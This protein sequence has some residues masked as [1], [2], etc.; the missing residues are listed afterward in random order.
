MGTYEVEFR[1]VLMAPYPYR[2]I[3][4]AGSLGHA[5]VVSINVKTTKAFASECKSVD[6]KHGEIKKFY[7]SRRV[8]SKLQFLQ[9]MELQ[10][11]G[12][13]CIYPV[14]WKKYPHHHGEPVDE[15]WDIFPLVNHTDIE[16]PRPSE[17]DNIDELKKVWESFSWPV[18]ELGTGMSI[19]T[20]LKMFE[21][22]GGR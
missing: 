12:I 3:R 8:R 6:T 1:D 2:N 4:A 20:W 7:V 15:K 16:W 13:P 9:M 11:D 17:Y 14:R 10:N 21:R 5:D 22:G 18:F 19:D